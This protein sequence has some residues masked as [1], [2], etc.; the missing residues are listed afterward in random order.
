MAAEPVQLPTSGSLAGILDV[1]ETDE[2]FRALISDEIEVPE[3]DID[4]SI[5]VGVPEG[6]RPAL[7][8]GA[9]GTRPVVLVVASGRE[10]EEMVEAIRS[11]Y[12]GDPNDVAQ[13]E[14]WET[15]PHERLSP[16]ADTVASR[17]AVFRRLMHPQEGSKLFGPIRILVMPVRSLIQPVVAGLGDVEPLVFSQGEELALDEA[18]HRLVENAYTRVDLV[19]DRGEFAVRGGI[20]DVFPPTLP[21]PVRIEFFGDEIDTIKEFHAS[22]QRTYGSDIPM[23]WATPCRELQLTEKV[24]VRAKSLI[25][26]I[27]NAEDM[28][29]SIANAIPVEGM[30]SLLPALVDDMEPV[31]GMLP[32]RALVMLSDPEKMRRAADDLAKTA[33]EFLAASWH[34][35]ASGHGAGAP[36]TFDQAN[37]YDFEETISSLV[38]SRHDVWKLTSFGVDSSREGRVQLDATNPGEYRGDEAKTASGIEGLLDAGYAVT[39]TA[40][41]QGTLV[42]LKRAINETGIANF[43]CIRSRAIDGFVDNA[44]KVALLTERDLTGRTS[45]AGQAKTPKRRRKAIDLMELKAGDYV[46]HEQHGIGRF[47]EMRQRTIG[48]GANQTTREYLVIEY[49]SSKRGAPADKLF[50]PTDQLDQVSKYIGADAPKLNKLGGSDWAAT[51]AKARKHVHE[52][53]ED[54]VK[55]YSARQRMQ[56][57]AF[58]KDTPWQKE[59]ED[60]FPYQETADQLTTIDEVKSDMEKPVPMDRLICGDVG[61]GKTEIAVRAAFKAV[62][63]SKQVAVLVPT[64][65][66][67]QQHFETFTE[68]FEGFPVEVRAMSRFQTTKEINDTIEGLED[69]SVDVVIG[70]HKLLGPKVKFKDLGLVIID[71]EQRFGVEHKETLKALRTNVDVLSLSATPIPRTLHMSMIGI[72]DMSVLEE[73][74]MDRVPIQTYVMEYDEETV[75]EA[76]SRELRRGGQVYYVY[77]RVNDIADVTARIA[78]L[79]PDAR[80]DF[81][82]G[83]MSER[84]LEAVMYAFINGDI[85]VLVSTTIIETGLDISNV[86]TMIIHDS[87]RYGLSQLYQLRGRIGRSNRTAYAFLMYRRN[88]MLKET[89]EKRLSAIREYTDLGSG[90]KIAMRDLELRGAGNLLGAEQHGHM[91]A[92][93]YDLY[94]KMLSEAVKCF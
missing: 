66:L 42:R 47:L 83:Q 73:P 19:M 30:E 70:T 90:F 61:F 77:N 78:K 64:T 36:I 6:L 79:L 10:A 22:D 15:L 60:A 27:P 51:K 2:D 7:A 25:G 85:D 32:K 11:W 35:A 20:I 1:L 43:D 76:I 53:A 80:V 81:A 3:S 57:Y 13:L 71:E 37:F 50:I 14:A 58:S 24:R 49:A 12:S 9:A 31:Q 29:E 68:R 93:G 89:A 34:V 82:H 86:N 94:C 52:I 38:F 4:P 41:A 87:D 84:E 54:L 33:N 65:L 21:H 59:L 18:S 16:R 45:A 8:A 88:T 46:V 39:V 69:G 40:G 75:R 28:L 91:N 17:M 55:L 44:A 26:S 48:A 74:P 62:Q 56:G 67:V 72:R 63:D 5:T 23:V 92:V